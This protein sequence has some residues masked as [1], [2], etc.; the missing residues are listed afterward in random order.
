MIEIVVN[1]YDFKEDT[2]STVYFSFDGKYFPSKDWTDYDATIRVWSSIL[3][4]NGSSG[5]ADFMDGPYHFSVERMSGEIYK[6]TFMI[7]YLSG[8]KKVDECLAS[9]DEYKRII[10]DIK[11]FLDEV[12]TTSI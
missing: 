5:S 3:S 2:I 12:G 7:E 11:S 4:E 9:R 6:F 8:L 1:K 10:S